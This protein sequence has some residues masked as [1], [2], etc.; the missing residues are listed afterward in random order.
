MRPFDFLLRTLGLVLALAIPLLSSGCSDGDL[1]EEHVKLFLRIEHLPPERA[2]ADEDVNLRAVIQ[3]SLEGPKLEAWV[4]IVGDAET[5]E[6]IPLTITDDGV[7]TAV[8]PGGPRGEV[9]RYVIEA[10]DAAGLV[11][12][13]P[14]GADEGETYS[15]RFTGES[16]RILGAISFLAAILGSILFV[17]A[18]AA[19]VQNLRGR[20]SA[21]PAGMLGGFGVILVVVGL[22]VLGAIHARQVT[23]QFWPDN[24]VF[25]ALARGDLALVSLVWIAN[26][27]VGRRLLLDEEPEGTPR[28]ERLFSAVAALLAIVVI[29]AALF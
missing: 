26:L 14:Q 11:V 1:A 25:F 12:S 23:G 20:M 4:R 15:L 17:G 13:L 8:L 29:L 9:V 6:R 3:S 7:A 24:A 21:G 18:G 10:R 5:D 2:A 16:S 28:G 27:F 19:A 22:L